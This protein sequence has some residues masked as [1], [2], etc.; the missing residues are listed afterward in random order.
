MLL[1][2]AIRISSLVRATKQVLAQAAAVNINLVFASQNINIRLQT[3]HLLALF[4]VLPATE[5]IPD[6]LVL[7]ASVPVLMAAQNII[8]LRALL[9]AKKPKPIIVIT[10]RLFQHL[11][12][13]LNIGLIA[14]PNVKL[15][16]MTIVVIVLQSVL[17]MVVKNITQIAHL[18]AKLLLQ[19]PLAEQVQFTIATGHAFLPINMIPLKQPWVWLFMLLPTVNTDR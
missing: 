13:V 1:V 3:V 9:S 14:L 2:N 10:E 11:M 8:L 15:H 19:S 18:S 16:I 6:V 12:A 7:S 4:S 17:H 5:N